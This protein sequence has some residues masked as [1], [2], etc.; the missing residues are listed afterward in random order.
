M[1]SYEGSRYDPS[2]LHKYLYASANPVNLAD[3]SGRTFF[4]DFGIAVHNVI[5]LSFVGTTLTPPAVQQ[6]QQQEI[7]T[8]FKGISRSRYGPGEGEKKRPDLAAIDNDIHGRIWEIKVNTDT[9]GALDD[10]ELKLEILNR[11]DPMGRKWEPGPVGD[12]QP[13]QSSNGK[14]T[15]VYNRTNYQVLATNPL[16]GVI[17][18]QDDPG[19]LINRGL[20][21]ATAIV[22]AIILA[23]VIPLLKSIL[24]AESARLGVGLSEAEFSNA[25]GVP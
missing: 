7:S 20:G 1:D 24:P 19:A 3:P 8:I 25:N 5:G 9:Q 16:P 23:S 4:S 12:Y 10:L 15:V 18:Y 14:F 17:L 22:G 2:S 13:F 21:A 11:L 6:F